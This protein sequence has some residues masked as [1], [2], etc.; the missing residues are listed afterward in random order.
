M[1]SSCVLGGQVSGTRRPTLPE[2]LA[3]VHFGYC[4]HH[5]LTQTALEDKK[6]DEVYNGRPYILPGTPLMMSRAVASQ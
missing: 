6:A 5:V 3:R 4:L 1:N 2:T